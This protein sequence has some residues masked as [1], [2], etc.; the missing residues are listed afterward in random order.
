MLGLLVLM[1][2]LDQVF[3]PPIPD[4]TTSGAQLVVARDGTPLRAFADERGVWRYPVRIEDVSPAYLDTLLNYEDRW[5]FRHPGVNPASMLRA[6]GQSLW[7]GRPIS[8]GSTLTMQV[9]R[10]IEPIPHTAGGKLWQMARALQ[11]ELRLSKREIL[12]LYLNL[13]P[14]GGPIEG[15]QAASYA[16]LGKPANR[17]SLAESALLAVLPQ[18]PSRLRPD[19]YPERARQA[20]DKVLDRL[21]TFGHQSASGIAD[22]RMEQVAARSLSQPMLAPH[23]AERL[24]RAEPTAARIQ[25]TL[26]AEWQ[27]IVEARVAAW[28]QRFPPATSAAVLVVDNASG[29]VRAY[30]GS[31]AF[32]DPDRLG[33]VDMVR[34]SRSPGSTLK[35]FLYGMALDA[36][37]IHSE[38]LLVDAPQSFGGYA[39]GN[40]QEAF[41]GPVSAAQALRLSLN[42][43]AVDLLDRIGPARFHAALEHAGL[44]LAL[45]DGATPNLSLI[46]G[47]AGA[48]LDQ[49]TALYLGLSQQGQVRPLRYTDAAPAPTRHLLSPGAAWI[50]RQM[51]AERGRSRLEAE[52]FDP[53]RARTLAWKT[54]TSYGFRDAWAL[55]TTDQRTLGVWI[56]RPDGTPLPGS[57]GVVS[58]LPLLTQIDQA[59]PSLGPSRAPVRPDSVTQLSICWPLGL[60]LADTPDALCHQRH[61]AWLLDGAAVPTLPDRRQ[62]TWSAPRVQFAVD[63]DTGQRLSAACAAAHPRT[64]SLEV[65]RWPLLLEPW[66]PTRIRR[67]STLPPL[68][69]GC[70]PDPLGRGDLVIEG[71]RPGSLLSPAG[72]A[73]AQVDLQL[74]VLGHEGLPVWWLLDDRPLGEPDT[75]GRLH[76]QLDADGEHRLLAI[77]ASGRHAAVQFEVRG[78]G[79]RAH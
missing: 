4:P 73:A 61:E 42:V 16:Y 46:L 60:A 22:A 48:R 66:L 15:V 51:L 55:A 56:G 37:L 14:Y 75:A 7:H 47:G 38:S 33:H 23:L 24:R 58:A 39:P 74:R 59:L 41:N 31:A 69:P 10:L 34:A 32:G 36:G 12:E 57:F 3:P 63:A 19:R 11:L 29:E 54:G 77:D 64:R 65:A 13:A 71:V 28:M 6:V 45:P 21:A 5:F 53:G 35:P 68:A 18:S 40:F 49:L 9:A 25:S 2:V 67:Q 44:I 20:R 62:M 1:G 27:R 30:V 70:G 52:L 72:S 76:L 79:R 8:G 26:D 17:L 43:P 50:V 78:F